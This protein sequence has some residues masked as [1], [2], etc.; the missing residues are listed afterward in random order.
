MAVDS[1]C[2]QRLTLFTSSTRARGGGP[3]GL[4]VEEP[5][6]DPRVA[7]GQTP[8][9]VAALAQRTSGASVDLDPDYCHNLFYRATL[10]RGERA[11]G[12]R[13]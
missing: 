5:S 6:R 7:H 9:P 3:G 8:L 10:C 11:A 12:R 2:R 1:T 13:I 4:A